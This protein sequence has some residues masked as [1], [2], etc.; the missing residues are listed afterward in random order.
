MLSKTSSRSS[1]SYDEVSS[2]LFNWTDEETNNEYI[3]FPLKKWHTI[4]YEYMYLKILLLMMEIYIK[5]QLIK[6]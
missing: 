2:E 1:L 3:N 6:F 4:V 5:I